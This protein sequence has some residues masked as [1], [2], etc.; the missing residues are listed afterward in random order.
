MAKLLPQYAFVWIGNKEEISGTPENVFFLGN[1]PNAAMYCPMAD[2]FVLPSNYEGLPIVI[3]EA[4]GSGLPV[5]ASNVGGV[6]E[7]VNDDVNGYALENNVTLFAEKIDYILKNPQVCDRMSAA[8]K[9]RY[10]R[11]FSVDKMVEGYKTVYNGVLG[12][13]CF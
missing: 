2:L 1:I 13:D 9:E 8:S 4:M 6:S 3:I 10:E 11:L 7:L 5:V 12:K